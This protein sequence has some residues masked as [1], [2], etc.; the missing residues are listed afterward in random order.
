M[1]KNKISYLSFFIVINFL[2]GCHHA[3]INTK[4]FHD[5]KL[6]CPALYNEIQKLE[7]Q[8]NKLASDRGFCLTNVGL[9]LFFPIGILPHEYNVAA[10]EDA[11]IARKAYLMELYH[12]KCDLVLEKALEP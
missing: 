4:E 6:S 12:R 2:T 8:Q 7:V 3:L 9:A 11:I 5:T 10:A 1:F